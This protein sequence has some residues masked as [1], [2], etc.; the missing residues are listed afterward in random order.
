MTQAIRKTA[1]EPL[2]PIAFHTPKAFTT[3]LA[4]G[5]KI[6]IF[7]DTRF[8]LVSYRLAFFSGDINDPSG[9]HGVSSA[10][11]AMLSEGTRN[12]SSRE[13]AEK[14]ERLGASISA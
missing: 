13:L 3:E 9:S 6:V 8:P 4:N 12:F 11:A 1:P 2:A 10:V 14:I 5:L 7:E